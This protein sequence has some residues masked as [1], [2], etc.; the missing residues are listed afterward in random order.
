[1]RTDYVYTALGL[2]PSLTVESD[3][4]VLGVRWSSQTDEFVFDMSWLGHLGLSL[5]FTKRSL[6]KITAMI[7]DPLVK[8]L[9]FLVYNT[10][11]V[12]DLT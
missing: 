8:S 6:L 2:N 9:S 5:L 10:V 3:S 7:F 1:M 12:I 11:H 4:K